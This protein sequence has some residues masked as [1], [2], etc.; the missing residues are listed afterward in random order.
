MLL[1][2]MLFIIFFNFV[3][4]DPYV[5]LGTGYDTTTASPCLANI[6]NPTN[7][8]T[9]TTDVPESDFVTLSVVMTSYFR[10]AAYFYEKIEENGFLGFG[11]SSKEIW[12]FYSN[13]YTGKKSLT[14]IFLTVSY[15][16]QT[17]PVIP[18]PDLNPM[19][20]KALEKLPP[21]TF[22]NTNAYIEF[23]KTF[24]TAVID[25]V[26]LGGRFEFSLSYASSFN[27]V[28]SEEKITDSSH[29]SFLNIIGDGHGS[30]SDNTWVD[31]EFNATIQYNYSYTGGNVTLQANRYLDWAE[32]VENDQQMIKCHLIPITFFIQ[33]TTIK[34]WILE[35]TNDF[36][37]ASAKS[38][39]TY[40]KSLKK[41]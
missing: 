18:F 19:F 10:A 1:N 38:L 34:E 20:I 9:F 15:I 30:S 16:R 13:Y 33:N 14:K 7:D 40:I 28:Y 32:T 23:F 29:W 12:R 2:K 8:N 22:K 27:D 31:K 35:A 6:Y 24:G 5:C 25:E 39:A 21:Y 17:S 41:N 4:S 26:I 3:F 11:S 36:E 37:N